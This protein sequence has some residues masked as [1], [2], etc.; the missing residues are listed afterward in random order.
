VGVVVVAEWWGVVVAVGDGGDGG[1][2]VLAVVMW[3]CALSY[4]ASV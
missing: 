2:D 4:T 1:N 3:L